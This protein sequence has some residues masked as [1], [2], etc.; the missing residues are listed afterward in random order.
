MIY[1]SQSAMSEL[2]QKKLWNNLWYVTIQ[3]LYLSCFQI[4]TSQSTLGKMKTRGDEKTKEGKTGGRL[5]W[6]G[7][8][9]WQIT[10]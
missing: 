3:C 2:W 8:G 4:P 1:H 10:I 7:L 9:K 5:G 6:F